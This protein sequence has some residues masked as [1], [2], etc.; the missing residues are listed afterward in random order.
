MSVI[1][2]YYFHN[3]SPHYFDISWTQHCLVHL[4]YVFRPPVTQNDG[5]NTGVIPS[6][7]KKKKKIKSR[8]SSITETTQNG[9]NRYKLKIISFPSLYMHVI[10]TQGLV[11]I[12]FMMHTSRTWNQTWNQKLVMQNTDFLES[13]YSLSSGN[14]EFFPVMTK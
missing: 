7:V 11:V 1:M 8:S 4:H 13:R 9:H 2:V 5:S 14:S 6:Y 10:I 12:G 3:D